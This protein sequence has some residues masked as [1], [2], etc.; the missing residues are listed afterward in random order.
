MKI[1]C[2]SCQHEGTVPDDKIPSAGVTVSC[3]KCKTR[4]QI[5]PPSNSVPKPKPDLYCPKCGTGQPISDTC[6]NCGTLFSK[7]ISEQTTKEQVVEQ[8]QSSMYR[9]IANLMMLHKYKIVSVFIVLIALIGLLIWKYYPNRTNRVKVTISNKSA[10]ES[11]PQKTDVQPDPVSIT[12]SYKVWVYEDGGYNPRISFKVTNR[13]SSKISAI[14]FR[15]VWLKNGSEQLFIARESLFDLDPGVTSKRIK[16]IPSNSISVPQ[17]KLD[18]DFNVAV[19]S[20]NRNLT[21]RV[22]FDCRGRENLVYDGPF[23]AFFNEAT[24]FF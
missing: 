15:A 9:N 24:P 14:S 21:V 22:Y 10:E 16:L 20:L 3:P 7:F 19:E 11:S 12:E 17:S 4:F 13:L 2:P 18:L 23:N 8:L 5:N 1:R 6:I